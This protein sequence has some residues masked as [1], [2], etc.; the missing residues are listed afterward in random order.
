[1]NKFAES[2]MDL[3]FWIFGMSL[4]LSMLLILIPQFL[5]NETDFRDFRFFTNMAAIMAP[6]FLVGIDHATAWLTRHQLLWLQTRYQFIGLLVAGLSLALWAI[7]ITEYFY[8]V[9]G[10]FLAI[11]HL[12][13]NIYRK[14]ER[15]TAYLIVSQLAPKI[16]PLLILVVLFLGSNYHQT[17]FEIAVLSSVIALCIVLSFGTKTDKEPE[18]VS[19]EKW[20]G[21]FAFGVAAFANIVILRLGYLTTLEKE[22]AP[23][24]VNIFD[25]SSAC[26]AAV[27]MPVLIK[28]R[29]VEIGSGLDV[30]SFLAE[31]R[32]FHIQT[33]IQQFFLIFAFGFILAVGSL[34]SIFEYEI[35]VFLGIYL[36]LCGQCLVFATFPNFFNLVSS[37]S[38]PKRLI[39][40]FISVYFLAW[41]LVSYLPLSFGILVPL[42]VAIA[43]IFSFQIFWIASCGIQNLR[44][45]NYPS[46]VAGITLIV[47]GYWC[48]FLAPTA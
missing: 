12:T 29:V 28:S 31:Y 40:F 26:A 10:F 6:I 41:L 19:P 36:V 7:N 37:R 42:L 34:L 38:N 30:F 16:A 18:P 44:L 14:D 48:Y 15:F 21:I 39:P 22:L 1:M 47:L 35:F 11:L 5:L 25:I 4:S 45:C 32:K 27:I 46:L 2:L 23:Q 8:I 9:F 33:L 3:G 17:H 43:L 24:I 20:L 13:G